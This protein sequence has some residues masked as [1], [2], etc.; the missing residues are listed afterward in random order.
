MAEHKKQYQNE[1]IIRI[2]SSSAANDGQAITL[3][4]KLHLL[5]TETKG[6]V[7][8]AHDSGS[9]R[10]SIRNNY[11]AQALHN[12]G[13]ATLLVDLLTPEE[14]ADIR[15]QN[16]LYRLP[17]G[18]VPN[19]FNTKLLAKRLITATNWIMEDPDTQDLINNIGYFGASTGSAAALIASSSV[20]RPSAISAIVSCGGRPDLAGS[21]ALS[22]V[23]VPTL[24]IV[25][26]NDAKS[27]IDFNN[28]ALKQLK[29][30]QKKKLVII[31]GATHLFEEAGSLKE[32]ARLASGWFGCYFLIKKHS[33]S[34]Q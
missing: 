24:L 7:L 5:P 11:V 30:V 12:A 13:I 26:G 4:G 23:Q 17:S 18:L 9:S 16:I 34:N 10:H 14:D 33:S 20:E 29:S 15:T 25:G 8:F 2:S 32:V 6:I 22:K 19:K 3:E 1:R 31:P 21:E 28:N 27:V